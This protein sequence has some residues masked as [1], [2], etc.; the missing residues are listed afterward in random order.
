[1]TYSAEIKFIL[2]VKK[3]DLK[4]VSLFIDESSELGYTNSPPLVSKWAR[5]VCDVVGVV[6]EG[7]SRDRWCGGG[8][9]RS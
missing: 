9:H 1:M 5:R 8:S 6:R 3:K 7:W 2:L 4:C